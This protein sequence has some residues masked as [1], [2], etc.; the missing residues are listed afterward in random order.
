MIKLKNTYIGT[1]YLFKCTYNLCATYNSTHTR[2]M[3]VNYLFISTCLYTLC[4]ADSQ[5]HNVVCKCSVCTVVN[6][7]HHLGMFKKSALNKIHYQFSAQR[8]CS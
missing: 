1:V 8:K 4:T 2:T 7:V 6:F 5:Q 3:Y